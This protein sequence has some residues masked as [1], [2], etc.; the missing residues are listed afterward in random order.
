MLLSFVQDYFGTV[1]GG[2]GSYDFTN[3]FHQLR[4]IGAPW[5]TDAVRGAR[6]HQ[7]AVT[8]G[9]TMNPIPA[10]S[11]AGSSRFP[12]F[13]GTLMVYGPQGVSVTTFTRS[14][15]DTRTPI[16]HAS[17]MVSLV[18]P[19]IVYSYNIFPDEFGTIQ[20]V[21]N[22]FVSFDQINLTFLP[23]PGQVMLLG[24]GLLGLLALYRLRRR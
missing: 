7:S 17:G 22:N 23:E 3:Y 8:S 12:F 1:A 15:M 19:N 16:Y 6:L 5:N 2:F 18:S 14:G 24:G 9:P 10:A 11:A 13:T 20:T 4:G 21:Q